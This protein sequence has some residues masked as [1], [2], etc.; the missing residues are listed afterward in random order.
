MN[1]SS[2][3]RPAQ[4]ILA[5]SAVAAVA[6]SGVLSGAAHPTAGQHPSAAAA[7]SKKEYVVSPAKKEY[8]V[9]PAKKEYAVSP[10]KKE[11]VVS[12]AKKE[13]VV[14][15]SK[16][17]YVL[18]AQTAYPSL[19]TGSY[20]TKVAAAINRVR[21]RHHLRALTAAKCTTTVATRWSAHLAAT[22]TFV[23][24]SMQRL[25]KRCDARYAG[26]TLAR[27]SVSPNRIVRLWLDSPPHRHVLLS[28]SPRHL[29]VGA[30]P[31]AAGE[32]VVAANFMRF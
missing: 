26:E 28:R 7:P 32:W 16:K 4:K 30:T 3:L 12:P 25:L 10:S 2:V 14:S 8:A 5:A 21:A 13:Y 23:H 31:N 22:D 24:Q 9:S 27:G 15:P 6:V 29:G 19:S 11:Y 17:E 1:V 20:E 18:A